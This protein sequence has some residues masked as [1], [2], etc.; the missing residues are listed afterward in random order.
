[1]QIIVSVCSSGNKKEGGKPIYMQ[2]RCGSF[3]F[4]TFVHS[5]LDPQMWNLTI[6]RTYNEYISVSDLCLELTLFFL[7]YSFKLI[8]RWI[9]LTLSLI[10]LLGLCPWWFF[11]LE[12]SFLLF[13]LTFQINSYSTL[14]SQLSSLL[15]PRVFSPQLFTQSPRYWLEHTRCSANRSGINKWCVKMQRIYEENIVQS[16]V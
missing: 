16:P 15:N 9:Y 13:F 7:F 4:L 3:F 1:M 10:F 6:E 5:W 11:L 8:N 14:W 12:A 2:Y